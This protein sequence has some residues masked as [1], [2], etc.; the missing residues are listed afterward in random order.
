V[1]ADG[2][3]IA[4]E[5][6]RCPYGRVWERLWVREAHYIGGG[7]R[8]RYAASPEVIKTEDGIEDAISFPPKKWRPSIH[9]P[10]WASRITLEIT[11]VGVERLN[12]ISEEDAIA[13]GCPGGSEN[14][15][16]CPVAPYSKPSHWYAD[17]WDK[18]NGKGSW[19]ANPWVWVIEF[20]RVDAN[21]EGS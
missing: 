8:V 20:R 4:P 13:E 5:L 7:K 15:Y 2:H 3:V 21:A 11:G 6:W 17:L 18:I 12:T 16:F 1:F 19:A 10:R 14:G 9:M